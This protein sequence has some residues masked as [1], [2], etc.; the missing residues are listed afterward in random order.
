MFRFYGGGRPLLFVLCRHSP[1]FPIKPAP[2]G[3]A[4]S[5]FGLYSRWAMV[6]Q[7]SASIHA[8]LSEAS[9]P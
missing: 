5:L 9:G 2:K 8:V 1:W 6:D 7:R 4:P 3:R